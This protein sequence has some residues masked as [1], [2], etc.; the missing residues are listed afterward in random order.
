MTAERL[1]EQ[2]MALRV[3]REFRDGD[4]VNLGIGL[5]T[6]C[7]NFLTP[8][9]EIVFH[10]ENG[11]LGFGPI[12]EDASEAD[13][14]LI[15]AGVQPISR[16]PGLSFFDQAESFAMVR[17][18][19]LDLAVLG[20]LQVSEAGDLANWQLPGK[21]LG[22]LGGGMDLAFC[23][24]RVIV[25]TTHT[26]KDGQPKILRHCSYPLTAPACVALIVTDIAVIEV[27]GQGLVLQ[28]LA[29]GWT[30]PEVQAL[31]EPRLIASPELK[32]M[33]LL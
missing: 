20:A 7:A 19:H 6:L 26:T 1:D 31:T 33:E 25:I 8:D 13:T 10:T 11:A 12:V 32:P 28:E 23:A 2:T 17:G 18:G 15:N 24:K 9:V 14:D 21:P 22:S 30:L 4:V 16:R 3:A 29:P 5:P 27:T